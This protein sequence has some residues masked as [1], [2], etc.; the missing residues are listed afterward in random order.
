MPMISEA[1]QP[2]RLEALRC[3]EGLVAR[4]ATP[5]RHDR[6]PKE[7]E[8]CKGLLLPLQFAR[9]T[10]TSLNKILIFCLEYRIWFSPGFREAAGAGPIA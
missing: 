8:R 2:A 4:L 7:A 6:S 3:N 9:Q 10:G 1:T 5:G